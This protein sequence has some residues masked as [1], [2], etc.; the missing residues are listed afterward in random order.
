MKLYTNGKGD[1]AGTQ[2][3]AKK[4]KG[5][6]KQVEVPVDKA[7][8]LD[9]LNGVSQTAETPEPEAPKAKAPR[10]SRSRSV[11]DLSQYDVHDVVLN[12][13]EEH[14]GAALAATI[15]RLQDRMGSL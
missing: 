15:A 3:D 1:W 7:G 11:E 2:A 13:N 5:G 4:L 10:H 8:L 14:L 6:F 12:C 9:Y